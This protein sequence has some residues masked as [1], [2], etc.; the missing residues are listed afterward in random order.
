MVFLA[1]KI[2]LDITDGMVTLTI[3]YQVENFLPCNEHLCVLVKYHGLVTRKVPLID[4]KSGLDN[5]WQY[6]SIDNFKHWIIENLDWFVKPVL[7]ALF[8]L[9]KARSFLLGWDNLL[10][11]F[12]MI[13]TVRVIFLV[14]TSS[15]SID[16]H[17]T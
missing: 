8:L 16:V 9:K 7:A 17:T 10:L 5:I 12:L 11:L 2:N 13:Q 3:L 14:N 6:Q 4:R 15:K 1:K